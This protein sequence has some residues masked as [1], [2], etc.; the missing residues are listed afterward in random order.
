MRDQFYAQLKAELDAWHQSQL[1]QKDGYEY[2]KTLVEFL[3]ELG[4]KIMQESVGAVPE[5]RNEKKR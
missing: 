4:Q 3:R 2:E 1:D 5:S